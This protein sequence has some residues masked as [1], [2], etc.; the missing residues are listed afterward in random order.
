VCV[1]RQ[2]LAACLQLFGGAGQ[3]RQ[4]GFSALARR[5]LASS[6]ALGCLVLVRALHSGVSRWSNERF[7][8]SRAT[9]FGRS[10]SLASFEVFR[11]SMF[12]VLNRSAR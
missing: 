5:V 1:A 8:R 10:E 4:F 11:C 6:A 3:S 7:Q 9:S 12:F 2:T